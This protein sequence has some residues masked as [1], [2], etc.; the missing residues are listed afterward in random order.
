[1]TCSICGKSIK[2]N[3]I[4]CGEFY[5]GEAHF[6]LQ[7]ARTSCNHSEKQLAAYNHLL[8]IAAIRQQQTAR[9]M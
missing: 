2:S 4:T 3:Q 8:K 5:C 7:R 9:L 1:M 6:F